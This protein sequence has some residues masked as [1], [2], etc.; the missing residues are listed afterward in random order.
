MKQHE[1][2][3]AVRGAGLEEGQVPRIH[4]AAQGA[5]VL[6]EAAHAPAGE[7]VAQQGFEGLDLFVGGLG[8]GLGKVRQAGQI[9]WHHCVVSP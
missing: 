1:A 3:L 7:L 2:A 5:F 8:Q 4:R 9:R 6:K